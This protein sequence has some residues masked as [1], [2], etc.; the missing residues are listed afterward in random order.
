MRNRANVIT[1]QTDI[2]SL[3]GACDQVCSWAEKSESHYVCVSNVHMCIETYVDA[4]FRET[5]NGADLIVPDGRPVFWAQRLLGF[6][7]ARQV[8]GMDLTLQLCEQAAQ[9]KI[10]VGFY[11]GEAETLAILQ[12]ELQKRWEELDI[13][14]AISPPFREL[15]D[16][17]KQAD[18]QAINASGAKI[19]FVGLGCPKQEAWMQEHKGKVHAVML[20]VGAAFDFIAG[21]KSPA[22]AWMQTCGLEWLHRLCSEPSRLWRRYLYTNPLFI[23]LFIRQL[24]K[25]SVG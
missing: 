12:A 1:M 4:V 18:I 7:Q 15:S 9:E 6:K 19:L 11:G 5:V 2:T 8:R 10:A 3:D 23:V 24:I 17:E 21:N 25:R 22:P 16:D 20:G 13:A 14:V